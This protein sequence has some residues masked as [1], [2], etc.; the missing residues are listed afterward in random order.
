MKIILLS[1]VQGHGKKGEIVDVND[2]YAKNYLIPKK[3]GVEATNKIINEYN[4]KLEKERRILQE[5]KENAIAVANRLSKTIV[6]VKVKCGEGKLYGSVTSQD[7]VNGLKALDITVDKKKITLKENI[8]SIG[9]F[10]ADIWL[11]KGITAKIKI[12]VIAE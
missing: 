2:G 5:E 7:I 3:F 9:V 8:K 1:D 4:Q 6:N 12:N 10:D 11:Y